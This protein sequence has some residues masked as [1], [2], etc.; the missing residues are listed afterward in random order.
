MNEEQVKTW[1]KENIS[2]DIKINIEKQEEYY[3]INLEYWSDLGED[4]II[5]FDVKKLTKENIT[6]ELYKWYKSFDAEEHAG[7]LYNL[8]GNFGTPTSLKALLEDAEE[9]KE[10]LR[11]IYE[12]LL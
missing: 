6:E 11:R 2:L 1:I 10:N 3:N 8:G 12:S 7:D 4:V 9:Q 5:S